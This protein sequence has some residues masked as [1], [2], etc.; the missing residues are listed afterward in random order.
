MRA[1]R[2]A[3]VKR[4]TK[5][6]D[7]SVEINLDGTGKYSFNIGIPFFEHMLTQIAVHSLIDLHIKA[8]GDLD[9]DAHHTVEDIGIALG[10]TINQ[11]LADKKGINRF[12]Y[13]YVPLDEALSRAVID[14]SGR[15]TLVYGVKYKQ[16]KTGAFEMALIKE[17][18]Q[19]LVN[20]AKITI[21]LNNLSGS[22]AHHQSESLFKA[23]ARALRMAVTVDKKIE[24]FIPSSKDTL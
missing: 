10:E 7:I 11:A 2:V 20:N 17:F 23:F 9:I 8:K 13:A 19:A 18:F 14:I 22:N 15:P 6:T 12:G 5:E 3:T 1:K 21:H 24:S 16:A 4:K